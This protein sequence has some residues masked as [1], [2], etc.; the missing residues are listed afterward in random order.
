MVPWWLLDYPHL[1]LGGYIGGILCDGLRGFV[2]ASAH[3]HS[4]VEVLV[5]RGVDS[6]K[7]VHSRRSLEKRRAA[8]VKGW[9]VEA[10][11]LCGAVIL[12]PSRGL[13]TRSWRGRKAPTSPP[14]DSRLALQ[15]S[16][17][18]AASFGYSTGRLVPATPVRTT[19]ARHVAIG[20]TR[21]I[22]QP[23]VTN[24]VCFVAR[25]APLRS[26]L[27][28]S[29]FMSS[30]Q[31]QLVSIELSQHAGRPG[32]SLLRVFRLA[33]RHTY[34]HWSG[35]GRTALACGRLG[36]RALGGGATLNAPTSC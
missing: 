30:R 14:A 33:A 8:R 35:H 27:S 29:L 13:I 9:R 22:L 2:N 3:R 4:S 5:D 26:L 20:E 23:G 36:R 28:A 34:T 15:L 7:G 31:T 16:V 24:D 1:S 11:M 10:G 21:H 17:Q 18:Q 12:T 25:R 6:C 19:I 32:C